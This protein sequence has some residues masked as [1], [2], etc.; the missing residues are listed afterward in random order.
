VVGDRV[1]TDVGWNEG[2]FV[3][4]P[5]VGEGVGCDVL[6]KVSL[7]SGS[8]HI[9]QPSTEHESLDGSVAHVLVGEVDGKTVGNGVVGALVGTRVGSLV[10]EVVGGSVGCSVGAMVGCKLY[11]I[12]S[13]ISTLGL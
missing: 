10:G 7:V 3:G 1:G 8:V 6:Q 9:S 13:E 12:P 11:V 2:A 4:V 5:V